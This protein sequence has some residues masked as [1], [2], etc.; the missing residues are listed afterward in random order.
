MAAQPNPAA[1]TPAA[2]TPGEQQTE[3]PQE[4]TPPPV[5]RRRALRLLGTLAAS[6]G[7]AALAAARPE[8]AAA[9][10]DVTVAGGSTANYGIYVAQTGVARTAV[11]TGIRGVLGTYI[12]TANFNIP[13]KVAVHGAADGRIG[14]AGTGHLASVGV[15]GI[16]TAENASVQFANTAAAVLGD[17][18]TDHGVV[19][20]SSVV[21]GIFGQT[22]AAA[23]TTVSGGAFHQ[24]AGLLASGVVGVSP[25]NVG[26]QGTS[27][28]S[29]GAGVLGN[30]TGGGAAV[31]GN[32]SSGSGG[33]PAISAVNTGPGGPAA[34][35]YANG[36]NSIGTGGLTDSGY[37]VYGSA[38]SSGTGVLGTSGGNAAVWGAASAA[39]AYSGLFTGGKGVV[40]FGALTVAGGPKSAAV[41]AADGTLR[42]LYSMESP[43]SWFEDFGSGQLS[44]GSTTVQLEPGFAGVVKTDQYRVFPVATGDCKGLYVSKKTPTSFT[45]HEVQGGTSN[46]AFDYRVVAKRKDIEGARL[47]PVAE[48]QQPTLPTLPKS[49]TPPS[50][51]PDHTPPGQR[52]R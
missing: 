26:V 19:G 18:T 49:P 8:Q 32:N 33:P 50:T 5:N 1:L 9:D 15:L 36:A 7:A 17:S 28:G 42:R 14:V 46:V 16:V 23:G 37:G 38:S 24:G 40:V 12:E 3:A 2:T 45:V 25:N 43:E 41:K 11:T 27:N 44:G 4:R 34:V 13:D 21:H 31:V 10:A 29:T 48:L 51:P 20:A 6:A 30:N 39:G 35:G 47:E 22:D 52:G